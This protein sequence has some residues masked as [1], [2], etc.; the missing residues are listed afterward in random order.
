MLQDEERN[1]ARLGLDS[2]R[3][4]VGIPVESEIEEAVVGLV[5]LYNVAS[6]D[7]G[8]FLETR[9]D[10]MDAVTDYLSVLITH[11]LRAV[12]GERSKAVN[13][14]LVAVSGEAMLVLEAGPGLAI[15]QGNPQAESMF[16]ERAAVGSSGFE[17][18]RA[19]CPRLVVRVKEA[20]G[21]SGRLHWDNEA[22][23]TL[24]GRTVSCNVSL[25]K[26]NGLGRAG[27]LMVFQPLLT[28]Q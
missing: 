9:R 21:E 4:V 27:W 18:L 24:A 8:G 1:L 25:V 15:Q 16:G 14:A 23:K 26:H 11:A 28:H 2:L 3:N 7:V 10:E 22:V 6:D 12:A 19:S 20:L 5:L 17:L 13:N